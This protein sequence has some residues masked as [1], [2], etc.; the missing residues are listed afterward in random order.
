MLFAE[1]HNQLDRRSRVEGVSR[2]RIGVMERDAPRRPAQH[3]QSNVGA[4]GNPIDPNGS[5]SEAPCEACAARRVADVEISRGRTCR[6]AASAAASRR[7]EREDVDRILRPDR[8]A[9]PLEVVRQQSAGLVAS[10][11]R[12]GRG[13]R[14]APAAPATNGSFDAYSWETPRAGQ[15]TVTSQTLRPVP[16]TE[17]GFA[18]ATRPHDRWDSP[19]P[20]RLGFPTFRISPVAGSIRKHSVLGCSPATRGGVSR[21][22]VTVPSG[23]QQLPPIHTCVSRTGRSAPV[24]TSRIHA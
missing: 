20:A 14:I 23:F 16:G 15:S 7:G 11:K 3:Q 21:R 9:A 19:S 10:Q 18:A 24:S 1:R 2:A 12:P 5:L 4:P 17:R 6:F 13:R 22:A 8:R